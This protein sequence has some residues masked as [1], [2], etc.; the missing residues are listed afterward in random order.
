MGSSILQDQFVRSKKS[1]NLR[2]GLKSPIK[3]KANGRRNGKGVAMRRQSR[4]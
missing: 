3:V 4:K 1:S 2:L